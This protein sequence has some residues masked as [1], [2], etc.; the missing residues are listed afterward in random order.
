MALK[1]I[2]KELQD[3]TKDPP[4]GCSAGPAG[5]DLFHWTATITG[6]QDSPYA[7]G[8]FFL[9][10]RFPPDYPFKPPKVNASSSTFFPNQKKNSLQFNKFHIF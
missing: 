2:Q 9:D 6:P 8:V 10:I 1:R 3:M 7:G 4:A 5:N